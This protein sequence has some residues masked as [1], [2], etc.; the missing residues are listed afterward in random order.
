AEVTVQPS[1]S[2][3]EAAETDIELSPVGDEKVEVGEV[4]PEPTVLPVDPA[5]VEVRSASAREIDVRLLP[6][7]TT[8]E[9]RQGAEEFARGA[10][11]GTPDDGVLLMGL[12]HEAH[13]GL[14]QDGRPVLTRRPAGRSMKVWEDDSG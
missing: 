5:D 7:N 11:L 8:I 10:T 13:M 2:T 3:E 9:T 1:I 6:W 12:E 4:A 14:G